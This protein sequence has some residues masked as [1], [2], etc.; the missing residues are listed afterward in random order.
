MCER[1]CV[2]EGV[3]VSVRVFVCV[4]VCVCEHDIRYLSN[5]IFLSLLQELSF[6]KGD[7]ILVL[8]SLPEVT[9]AL[10]DTSIFTA[11]V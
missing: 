7:L 10:T 4:W 2:R 3:Y 9:L 5:N 1:G 8:S 11:Y 6:K